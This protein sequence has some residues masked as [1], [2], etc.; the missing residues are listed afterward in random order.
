LD[1]FFQRQKAKSIMC[2]RRLCERTK[3][4]KRKGSLLTREGPANIIDPVHCLRAFTLV[5]FSDEGVHGD[6]LEAHVNE[7]YTR[8]SIYPWSSGRRSGYAHFLV[9]LYLLLE[10]WHRCWNSTLDTIDNLISFKVRLDIASDRV[11]KLAVNSVHF[12]SKILTA[13]QMSHTL[14]TSHL[15]KFMFDKS[16][17]MDSS[18]QY[19]TM[20]QTFRTIGQSIDDTI[21]DWGKTRNE[22]MRDNSGKG[23]FNARNNLN[24]VTSNNEQRLEDQLGRVTQ[25][26]S[27]QA[28][29]LRDR[30]NRKDEE[31][32]AL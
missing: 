19:F 6:V 20:L 11:Q 17:S 25:L 5:I 10:P 12:S 30:I 13:R 26:L 14:G 32:K 1:L 9:A 23:I 28:K 2:L 21:A 18:R 22:I 31:V 29:Q 27:S 15:H 3:E 4:Q 8:T 16:G 24:T 7:S